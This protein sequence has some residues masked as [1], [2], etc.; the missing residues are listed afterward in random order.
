MHVFIFV[1][2]SHAGIFYTITWLPLLSRALLEKWVD[3]QVAIKLSQLNPVCTLT[4]CIAAILIL[5]SHLCMFAV[6]FLS[7]R[8]FTEI[9]CAL[10]WV[11]VYIQLW[12][13]TVVKNTWYLLDLLTLFV[14]YV[15]NPF[16]I[17]IVLSQ[18]IVCVLSVPPWCCYSRLFCF[19][20]SVGFPSMLVVVLKVLVWVLY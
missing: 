2:L 19:S 1:W 8:I 18:K 17:I 5:V 11:F 6:S 3:P 7:C 20:Q 13:M 14:F 9:L 12:F 10:F 15:L 4:H 16:Q